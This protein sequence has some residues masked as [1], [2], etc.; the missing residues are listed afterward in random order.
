M[1]LIFFELKSIKMD[2][3]SVSW[4]ALIIFMYTDA[5]MKDTIRCVMILDTFRLQ[6]IVLERHVYRENNW[7]ANLFHS[8]GANKWPALIEYNLPAYPN[9]IKPTGSL[10]TMHDKDYLY[11]QNFN[12]GMIRAIHVPFFECK[13][14]QS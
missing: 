6:H 1:F 8:T 2:L 11:S 12:S 14:I 3:I 10:Y 13:V 4:L 9:R 5:K 7:C